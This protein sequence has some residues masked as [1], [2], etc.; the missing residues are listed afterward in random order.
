MS[1]ILCSGQPCAAE[2]SIP[3]EFDSFLKQ[4]CGECHRGSA[5]SGGWRLDDLSGDMASLDAERRWTRIYDQLADGDMPPRDAAQPEAS[6]RSSIQKQMHDWLH[7]SSLQRQRDQGRV[8]I[9]RLNATEY[10][11]I[12]QELLQIDTPLKD[13]LP[14][15]ATTAGFDKVS[16]GLDMS[17]THFLRLQ[18]AADRAISAVVPMHPP[19]PFSDKRTGRNMT[20]KGPNFREGLGRTSQLD[21]D[22]LIFYTRLPRYG[23]CATAAVPSAGRYKV[24]VKAAAVGGKS[25]A[26]GLMR[27]MQSGREGPVLFDVIESPAGEPEVITI[28]CNLVARQAFVLNML[29]TWDIRRFKKPIEEYTGPGLKVEWMTI[30]GPIGEFPQ[31]AYATLYDDLALKARSVAIAEKNGLRVPDVRNRKI[32]QHWEADP[33]VPVSSN[34][35]EDARRLIERFLPR[36]F[37]RPV[38]PA[39]VDHFTQAI[40]RKLDSGE[41]FCD[42]MRYG[43]QLILTSPDFLFWLDHSQDSELSGYALASRLA[44]FLWV[45]APDEELIQAATA[46]RLTQRAELLAQVDRM[47][48]SPKSERF[49]RDFT[50]QWLDMRKIDFTIPDPVLYAD[51]DDLLL[52]SMPRETEAFFAEVL[53]ENRSLLE[54]VHS[55]WSMINGRLATLYGIEDIEGSQLRKVQL[56][57]SV[58]RGGVMTHASVLKVTADGTRTSPVLRGSWILDRIVGLPPSPP[59]PD[60]PPIEPDIRGATTIRQQLARHRDTPSC[61]TCHNAIDPPGFALESFDPIGNYREFYRVTTRSPRGQVELPYGSGRPIYRGLDVE[62]GGVTADGQ[63]FKDIDQYKQLLLTDKDQLA[64]SLTQKLMIYATGGENQF[65]DR[66]VIEEILK[67]VRE[68]NYGLRTLIYEIVDSRAFRMR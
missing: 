12:A 43:Y 41:L 22:A 67:K 44:A 57:A 39:E 46:G 66:E 23:L 50:A 32:P 68:N 60:I 53:R 36:A 18:E 31:P 10:E 13:L 48:K 38:T 49:V 52:W 34:P 8:P 58:H 55:D 64:R 33:L 17:A 2:P 5:P 37:R 20:E 27:V 29:T 21:G 24:Q 65:A 6:L 14:E 45:G 4:Y 9:R 15:D 63:S 26:V 19:I 7:Q 59:P 42:A 28:E 11:H 30:E 56:P 47:L 1:C 25:L 16:T 40:H 3:A 61:A 51:F 35:R 54:F 62:Q